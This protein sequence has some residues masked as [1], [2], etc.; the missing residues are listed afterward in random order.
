MWVEF[1]VR[2]EVPAYIQEEFIKPGIIKMAISYVN[3]SNTIKSTN[4]RISISS[5]T[6]LYPVFF[7]QTL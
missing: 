6:Y 1:T 3:K 2:I 5:S 4:I 7:N